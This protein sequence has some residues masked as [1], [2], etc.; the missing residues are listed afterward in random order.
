[1]PLAVA[2]LGAEEAGA[3]QREAP[4]PAV[5]ARPLQR[6]RADDTEAR[7][8]D[9]NQPGPSPVRLT[10]V[11]LEGHPAHRLAIEAD[12]RGRDF[13]THPHPGF[14]QLAGMEARDGPNPALLDEIVAPEGAMLPALAVVPLQHDRSGS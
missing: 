2:Q 6:E 11:E 3:R 12:L 7:L 1:M 13:E 4:R 9:L 14:G 10:A 5:L 8:L